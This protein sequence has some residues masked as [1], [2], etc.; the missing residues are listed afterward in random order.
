MVDGMSDGCKEEGRH[1]KRAGPLL[2]IV[3]TLGDKKNLVNVG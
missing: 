3:Q 2:Y 1:V